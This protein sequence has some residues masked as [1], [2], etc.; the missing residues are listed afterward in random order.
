MVYESEAEGM[1]EYV[2]GS[3]RFTKV[4]VRPR[5]VVADPATEADVRAVLHDAHEKCIIS[6]SISA[7]VTMEAEVEIVVA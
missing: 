7:P 1:M 2:D 5:V 4:V 6:N 3:Y